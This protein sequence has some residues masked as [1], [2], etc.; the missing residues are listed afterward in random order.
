MKKTI[1]FYAL[2]IMIII[3]S[4]LPH[5]GEELFVEKSGHFSYLN[6]ITVILLITGLQLN[7]K[8]IKEIIILLYSWSLV[9]LLILVIR[10]IINP[11][12]FKIGWYLLGVDMILILIVTIFLRRLEK[13]QK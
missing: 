12:Y 13:V 9:L 2:C 1:L 8:Y 11:T 4:V 6:L 5:L 10:E 3:S 7:W